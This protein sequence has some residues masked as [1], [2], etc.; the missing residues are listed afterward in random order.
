MGRGQDMESAR[1]GS[2]SPLRHLASWMTMGRS[3]HP[4]DPCYGP[5][6]ATNSLCDLGPIISPL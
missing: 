2:E 6:S 1:L 3:L 5:G 4:R